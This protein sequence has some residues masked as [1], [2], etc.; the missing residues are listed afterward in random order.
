[1]AV[2]GGGEG[3]LSN[4]QISRRICCVVMGRGWDNAHWGSDL[5]RR[6]PC[7]GH[8]TTTQHNTTQHKCGVAEMKRGRG[9]REQQT[10]WGRGQNPSASG[11][12]WILSEKSR[13]MWSGR[14]ESS[15]HIYE[16]SLASWQ[17]AQVWAKRNQLPG[18]GNSPGN[19]KHLG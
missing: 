2:W 4:I 16:A 1:M 5:T 10:R 7:C 11:W 3:H 8:N 15:K 19:R 6:W 13:S 9:R 18:N 17:E 14:R 12:G